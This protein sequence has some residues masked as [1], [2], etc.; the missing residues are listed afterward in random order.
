LKSG[1]KV[2]VCELNRGQFANI[3]RMN[4]QDI[5]FHQYNKVQGQ[6]FTMK[7]LENAFTELLNS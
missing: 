2:I 6:P 1:K 4:Y 5:E 3:L 7:E